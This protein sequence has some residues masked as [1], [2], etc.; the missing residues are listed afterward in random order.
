M[1]A[2][3]PWERPCTTC[4][5][6]GRVVSVAWLAWHAE[7][8]RLERLTD[9]TARLTALADHVRQAPQEPE[10]AIC[11]ECGGHSS[12]A[13][14]D[15]RGTVYTCEAPDGTCDVFDHWADDVRTY[16]DTY[17]GAYGDLDED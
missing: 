8:G 10:E 15:E 5:G 9:V 12:Y 17:R 14:N 7:Y 6:S 2:A 16:R 4:D 3:E 13:G 1:T 11:P